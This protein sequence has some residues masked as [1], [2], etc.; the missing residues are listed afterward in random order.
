MDQLW[1][2]VRAEFVDVIEWDEGGTAE[3]GAPPQTLLWRFDRHGSE[4]KM[5]AQLTVRPGQW[6]VF[7]NEGRIADGFGPGRY[8][9]ETRNLPVLTTCLLYTSPSPRDATLSR[10]PS[11]A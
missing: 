10:M 5:G 6:A 4:I 11:S 9:L 8:R 1:Q 7:V 2:K 3:G